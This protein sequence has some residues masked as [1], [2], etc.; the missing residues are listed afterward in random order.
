MKLLTGLD[1]AFLYLET[2]R[3]PLHVA[4]LRI[5]DAETAGGRLGFLTFRDHLAAR[6]HRSESSASGWS[7][8]RSVWDTRIGSKILILISICIFGICIYPNRA[9]GPNYVLSSRTSSAAH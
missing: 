3:M 9:A 4:A 1:A 7:W 8:Y 2:P 6:L 5:F